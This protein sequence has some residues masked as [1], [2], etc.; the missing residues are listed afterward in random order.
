MWDEI[1]KIKKQYGMQTYWSIWPC[2]DISWSAHSLNISH[3]SGNT[4]GN[5]KKNQC[6]GESIRHLQRYSRDASHN[7]AP[8][9]CQICCTVQQ[10]V[11]KVPTSYRKPSH[12]L[13]TELKCTIGKTFKISPYHWLTVGALDL[14]HWNRMHLLA[15]E[16]RLFRSFCWIFDRESPSPERFNRNKPGFICMF[17]P[18]IYLISTETFSQNLNIKGQLQMQSV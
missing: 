8:S 5:E 2:M 18:K 1:P 10:V 13:K 11:K 9:A 3:V 4:Y 14:I 16:R 6:L 12:S 7:A 15:S 17:S